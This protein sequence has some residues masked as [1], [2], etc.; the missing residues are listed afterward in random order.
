M[1]HYEIKVKGR[2]ANHWSEWFDGLEINHDQLGNTVFTGD[3]PDQSALHGL[4]TKIRDMNLTLISVGL[5][6]K[7]P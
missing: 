2:L 6:P 1:A 5:K 4:L 7:Q 3:I